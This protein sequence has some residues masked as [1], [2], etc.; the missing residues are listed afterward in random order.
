MKKPVVIVAGYW[1]RYPLG[2]H[3]LGQLQYLVGLQKLGCEVVFLEHFGWPSSCYNPQ[4]NTM[5]D[6]PSF[7]LTVLKREFPRFGLQKWCY[8]DAA[9]VHH[10]LSADAVRKFCREVDLLVSLA[11]TTWLDE[12]RGCRA[13]AYVDTDPGFTQFGMVPTPGPSC[14][15]YASPCD[16]QFHFTIGTRIGQPDCPIPTH[17]LQWRPTRWPVVLELMPYRCLPDAEFFT[18]VMS[19]RPRKTILHNGIEYGQ[20]DVEFMKFIDLPK[21]VGPLFKIALAGPNAPREEIAAAGWRLVDP[22]QVTATPW[23][24]RDYI[25][26][27]RG[28]FGVAVNLEVKARSGWVGDRT[29]IYLAMGKPVIIQETGF[30]ELLPCGEGLFAFKNMEEA[31]AAIESVNRNYER[32]CRAARRIAEEYFDSQKVLRTMLQACG[33]PMRH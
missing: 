13:R 9:G 18:T 20:K 32:H 14:A 6:D 24:Y 15:G 1:V 16:F 12:F 5:S 29:P 10:G 21:R 30:S 25:A 27:S 31:V 23:T 7:G 3:L 8:I 11:S 28:E 17:G 26:G 33:L 22:L 2:G 4:T 19:W